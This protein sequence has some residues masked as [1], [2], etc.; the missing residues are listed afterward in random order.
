MLA[1]KAGPINGNICFKP[2]RRPLPSRI[3]P[4]LATTLVSPF[5]LPRFIG[6]SSSQF[7][8]SN[9]IA[10]FHEEQKRAARRTRLKVWRILNALMRPCKWRLPPIGKRGSVVPNAET[11]LTGIGRNLG[12]SLILHAME[13]PIL[14]Q[15]V[16]IYRC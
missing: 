7:K 2:R 11:S 8:L 10:A 13:L 1:I 16:I 9:D 3:N 12:D 15:V 14:G 5:L 6:D 4:A